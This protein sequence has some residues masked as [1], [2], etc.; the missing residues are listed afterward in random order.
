VDYIVD[1]EHRVYLLEI[2]S[3]NS[4]AVFCWCPSTPTLNRLDGP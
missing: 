4:T 2:N 1:E 3:V